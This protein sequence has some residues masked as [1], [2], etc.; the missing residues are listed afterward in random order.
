MKYL[1][2]CP[3][4]FDPFIPSLWKEIKRY[5][6]R[7]D[8]RYIGKEFYEGD[9]LAA[10][11]NSQ[12]RWSVQLREELRSFSPDLIAVL[13]FSGVNSQMIKFLKTNGAKISFMQGMKDAFISKKVGK[14]SS[15][16]DKLLLVYPHEVAQLKQVGIDS[17]Y[18]GNPQTDAIRVYDYDSNSLI[19]NSGAS[20]GIILNKKSLNKLKNWLTV[21]SDNMPEIQFIVASDEAFIKKNNIH[22]VASAKLLDLLKQCNVALVSPEFSLSATLLNCPHLVLSTPKFYWFFEKNVSL[23]NVLARKEQVKQYNTSTKHLMKILLE[24]DEILNNHQYYA[25]IVQDLQKV[26]DQL[27]TEPVARKAGRI[28]TEWIEEE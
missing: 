26:K 19:E 23:V 17:V 12:Y 28:L 13:G 18:I 9:E 14:I 27:G 2:I 3:E 6:V 10:S 11:L 24:L 21:L 7:A 5:D 16:I 4:E 20:V 8:I 1:F 15:L 25:S 22:F